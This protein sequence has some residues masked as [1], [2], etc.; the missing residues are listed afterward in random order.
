MGVMSAIFGLGVIV[1]Y[2]QVCT[3]NPDS[4]PTGYECGGPGGRLRC[5][6]EGSFVWNSRQL[7]RPMSQQVRAALDSL[8]RS[9]YQQ[10]LQYQQRSN[11]IPVSSYYGGGGRS[12]APAGRNNGRAPVSSA[13]C[14]ILPGTCSDNNCPRTEGMWQFSCTNEGTNS[15][16]CMRCPKRN[17][18]PGPEIL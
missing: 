17:T 16:R 5:V 3:Q 13:P 9:A 15:E 12:S 6:P 10:A 18:G 11:T 7:G 1:A 14:R 2:A 8:Y 4:C